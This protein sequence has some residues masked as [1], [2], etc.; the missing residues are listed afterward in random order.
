M[1]RVHSENELVLKAFARLD[2]IAFGSAVGVISGLGV[3]VA[4]VALLLRGGDLVGPR[5]ALLGQYFTGYTVTPVGS[6]VGLLYGFL[7]GF[8]LGCLGALLRNIC[9]AVYLHA[10]RLRSGLSAAHDVLDPP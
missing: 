10:V 7:L 4:T 9:L 1:N 6:L 8:V 2:V 5:L 3:F